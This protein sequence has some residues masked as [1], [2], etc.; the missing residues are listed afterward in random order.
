[1]SA[2]FIV[3]IAY[4][5]S[6]RKPAQLDTDPLSPGCYSVSTGYNKLTYTIFGAGPSLL[7][8]Q[9]PGWGIGPFYLSNGQ[10]PLH[11]S[12]KILYIF[13]AAHLHPAVPL[14]P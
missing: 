14:I 7:T 2:S 5:N 3:A 6:T 10:A 8:C 12:F 9:V 13:P 4:A 1:M 11:D